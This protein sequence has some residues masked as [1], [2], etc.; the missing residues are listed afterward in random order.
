M[1]AN[2][3]LDNRVLAKPTSGN[4]MLIGVQHF[5]FTADELRE[6]AELFNHLAGQLDKEQRDGT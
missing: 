1:S 4:R 5:I 3:Y 2:F 6:A